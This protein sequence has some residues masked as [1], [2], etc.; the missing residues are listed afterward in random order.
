MIKE[1]KEK[2][3]KRL[4]DM[5]TD[6]MSVEELK[7][8]VKVFGHVTSISEKSYSDYLEEMIKKMEAKTEIKCNCLPGLATGNAESEVEA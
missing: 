3:L 4:N 7:E 1:I 8:Y 6:N 2:V 5:D